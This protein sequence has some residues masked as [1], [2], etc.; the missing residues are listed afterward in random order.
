MRCY[1]VPPDAAAWGTVRG[2]SAEGGA[3]IAPRAAGRRAGA[4]RAV[5][6]RAGEAPEPAMGVERGGRREPAWGSSSTV[7]CEPGVSGGARSGSP[8]LIKLV[9]LPVGPPAYFAAFLAGASSPSRPSL[10][11]RGRLAGSPAPP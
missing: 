6:V 2:R 4:A 10:R 8:R 3:E 11:G 5:S 9:A 1:V 7:T